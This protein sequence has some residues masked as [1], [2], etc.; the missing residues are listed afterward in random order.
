VYLGAGL[1]V[2]TTQPTDVIAF[3][4]P[5]NHADG[6]NIVFAD[7]HV[8]VMDPVRGAKLIV[9]AE[10]AMKSRVRAATTEP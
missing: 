9:G 6:Y 2:K 1:N 8:A 10:A 7:N 5:A 3:D 4:P